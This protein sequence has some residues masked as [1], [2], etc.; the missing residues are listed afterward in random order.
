MVYVASSWRNQVYPGVV[1]ILRECGI[2]CYDV[3]NP[4]NGSGG[5]AWAAIDPAWESWTV[6]QYVAAL[7]H[8]L[9]REGF[10]SDRVAMEAASACVLVLPC[11][12]SAH[13]E[14]GWFAG[15][16]IPV[17]VL[18][19]DN[20]EPELMYRVFS[21]VITRDVFEIV[22]ALGGKIKAS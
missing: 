8:P 15:R 13:T 3:R 5:F 10:H 4:P 12:R 7:S 19:N 6:E 22:K 17:H 2:E 18:T 16:G 1:D 11:G 21:G 20:Q 9:A 14:A